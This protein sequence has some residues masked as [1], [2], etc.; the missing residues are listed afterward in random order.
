MLH[1]FPDAFV[2]TGVGIC[3][4][5]YPARSVRTLRLV[6]REGDGGSPSGVTARLSTSP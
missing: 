4:E 1:A 3:C 5:L 6:V 2:H